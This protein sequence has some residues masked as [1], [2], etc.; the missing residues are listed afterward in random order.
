MATRA[1]PVNGT[2][3]IHAFTFSFNTSAIFTQARQIKYNP[4]PDLYH[5]TSE[6]FQRDRMLRIQVQQMTLQKT[7]YICAMIL[8]V[9]EDVR[10]ACPEGK[11]RKPSRK[12]AI[13]VWVHIVEFDNLYGGSEIPAGGWQRSRT[14]KTYNIIYKQS[15]E[16]RGMQITWSRSS[17]SEFHHFRDSTCQR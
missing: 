5:Q 14:S 11:L 9:T 10:L 13:S 1:A 7:H 16:N 15:G 17:N 2:N 12:I 8:K 6:A 3:N 4:Q